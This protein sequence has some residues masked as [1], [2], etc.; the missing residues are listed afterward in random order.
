M[1]EQNDLH[2]AVARATGETVSEVCRR[3]FGP[4]D[5]EFVAFDPEPLETAVERYLDWDAVDAQR[6]SLAPC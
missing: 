2:R 4:A 6:G 5:P 3:G 1:T